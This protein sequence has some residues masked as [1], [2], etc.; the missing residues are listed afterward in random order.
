MPLIVNV[1]I[2]MDEHARK[3]KRAKRVI[4][5]LRIVYYLSVAAWFIISLISGNDFLR[6]SNSLIYIFIATL[7]LWSLFQ[8]QKYL[9][10][11]GD[12]HKI[13]LG[14]KRLINFYFVIFIFEM[15][16]FMYVFIFTEL[17]SDSDLFTEKVYSLKDCRKVFAYEMIFMATW[18]IF[19]TRVLAGIYINV[20]QSRSIKDCNRELMS[21]LESNT[22]DND[23]Q[24]EL[25]TPEELERIER[26]KADRK[27]RF[28]KEYADEQLSRIL[29]SLMRGSTTVSDKVSIKESPTGG[30]SIAILSDSEFED[31]DDVAFKMK[32]DKSFETV[33]ENERSRLY[34]VRNTHL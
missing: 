27:L 23:P 5:V 4:L 30:E 31:N 3:K 11:L 19:Y 2:D 7:F 12:R 18:I 22:L 24:D 6:R 25:I 28:Y 14:N 32:E 26:A 15:L 1:F 9:K 34:E 29:T 16:T 10:R 33:L 17:Y 20:K 13:E 8:I 21:V